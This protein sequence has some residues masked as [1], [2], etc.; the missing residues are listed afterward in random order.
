VTDAK[1]LPPLAQ[2][3][4]ALPEWRVSLDAHTKN[5]K[6]RLCLWSRRQ[7]VVG[8]WRPSTEAAIEA[9][10]EKI[11]EHPGLMADFPEFEALRDVRAEAP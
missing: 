3:G 2:I 1:L 9:A 7:K 4:R 6:L 11:L 8:L 10:I 5:G